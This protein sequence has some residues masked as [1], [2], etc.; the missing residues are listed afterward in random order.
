MILVK[1][2]KVVKNVENV[3]QVFLTS[4]NPLLTSLTNLTV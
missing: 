4:F 1:R 2:V 3:K